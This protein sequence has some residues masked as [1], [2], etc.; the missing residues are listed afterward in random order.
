MLDAACTSPMRRAGPVVSPQ[1]AA[2]LRAVGT[3]RVSTP[4]ATSCVSAFTLDLLGG[5]KGRARRH[6]ARGVG[7]A[8][9]RTHRPERRRR[10]GRHDRS[11]PAAS[12][13][14]TRPPTRL[15]SPATRRRGGPASAATRVASRGSR[16]RHRRDRRRLP[17]GAP[18]P[19]ARRGR[20]PHR[21]VPARRRSGPGRPAPADVTETPLRVLA[22]EAPVIVLR[23]RGEVVALD[24]RCP[25]RGG[26]DGRGRGAR[27]LHHVPVARERVPTWT[28]ARSCRDRRP[29]TCPSYEC[30]VTTTASRCARADD[31]AGAPSARRNRSSVW[32]RVLRR[33][34]SAA[35][36][37]S[38]RAGM[39]APT[40][41]WIATAS[42]SGSACGNTPRSRPSRN[43]A[44]SERPLLGEPGVLHRG[45]ALCARHLRRRQD[46]RV[47]QS[48]RVVHDRQ[49]LVDPRRE[50]GHGIGRRRHRGRERWRSRARSRPGTSRAPAR[51][52]TGSGDRRRASRG[53]RRRGRRAPT[54]PSNRR[55]GSARTP[56]A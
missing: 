38:S 45:E 5:R 54:S 11:A 12:G 37:R 40:T 23:H 8:Q 51:P 53:R 25:H 16:R 42:V 13:W 31:Q 41:A 35:G 4:H 52:A 7:R 30:R 20:R 15:R 44:T 22:G 55:A 27:R 48:T 34:V 19:D 26:A 32:L 47:A 39:R 56:S 43:S 9:R 17:R 50:R 14:C 24:A 29:S 1:S 3:A 36:S 49:V 6:A 28:T 10:L 21:T 33:A 2:P 18:P 46:D